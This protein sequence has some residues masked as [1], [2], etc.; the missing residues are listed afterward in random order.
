VNLNRKWNNGDVI[1][2]TL[3]MDFRM[4]GYKGE[5][6]AYHGH[7][8]LEYGPLLMAW[9]SL[10]GEKVSLPLHVNYDKLIKSLQPL[11]GKPLH[12]SIRGTDNFEYM[13]YFEV[14]DEPFTCF[15]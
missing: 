8:S 4:T 5:E 14:Q 1:S 15:P 2:F 9:V 10:K 12:F 13:P 6:K 7:Y 3:P 11:P